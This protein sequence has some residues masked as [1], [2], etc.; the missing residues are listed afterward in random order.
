MLVHRLGKAEKLFRPP[1]LGEL[2]AVVVEVRFHAQVGHARRMREPVAKLAGGAVGGE[3]DTSCQ[4]KTFGLV[5]GRETE[6]HD[7]PLQ[8]AQPDGHRVAPGGSTDHDDPAGPLREP[9]GKRQR[10][11]PAI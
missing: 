7:P 2:P 1:R 11:H 4:R 5:S 8:V 10:N 9:L 3:R 6:P